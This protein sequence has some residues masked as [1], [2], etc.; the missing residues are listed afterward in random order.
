MALDPRNEEFEQLAT[1][2][3]AAAQGRGKLDS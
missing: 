3:L 2:D 1:T